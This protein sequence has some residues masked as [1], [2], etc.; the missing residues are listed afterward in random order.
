MR[1]VCNVHAVYVR[2]CAWF[3]RQSEEKR[4]FQIT[5][6]ESVQQEDTHG[7]NP[8]CM[9][10][11]FLAFLNAATIARQSKSS[12]LVDQT[13]LL[14]PLRPYVVHVTFPLR[15][16]PPTCPSACDPWCLPS[17]P[18]KLFSLGLSSGFSP[19]ALCDIDALP[20]ADQPGPGDAGHLLCR[21][22]PAGH[23]VPEGRPRGPC[24][25]CHPSRGAQGPQQAGTRSRALRCAHAFVDV[26]VCVGSGPGDAALSEAV[27]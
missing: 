17:C 1:R 13:A 6:L 7:C 9:L 16:R 5:A 8:Q 25:C 11:G 10:L 23:L 4:T 24:L 19:V 20:H 14:R 12:V 18:S 22:K 21:G 3:A 2:I 15:P 27:G 26:Y